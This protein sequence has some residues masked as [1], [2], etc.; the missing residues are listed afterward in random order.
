MP[1]ALIIFLALM[2]LARILLGTLFPVTA[3][4]SYYWLWSRHLTLSY[5]DHPP[6]VAYVNF[7]FTF[8]QPILFTL[9]LATTLI[10]LLVSIVVYFLAKEVYNEK[11]AFWSA[12]L[13]Q[14]IPHFLV[15]WL[16]MF[17]ELPLVLFWTTALLTTVYI[18]KRNKTTLWYLLAIIIGLGSLCKYTMFVFWPSLA[19]FFL[20]VPEQRF[21]LKTKEPYL[22]FI[23]SLLFFTPVIY[24]NSL[25]N[26]V[27]FTFH[28]A[29]TVGDSFGNNFLPFIADQLV[30][31]S[32][33]L[34]FALFGAYKY[35]LKQNKETRL[36][37]SFSFVPLFLFLILSLKVKVWAHW[38][39][40]GYIAAI[41]LTINYLM[42][43]KKKWQL[44]ITWIGLFSSLVI[45]ML[46]FV[47]PGVLL[48]QQE[49]SKNYELDK[50]IPENTK[51]FSQ[52]NVSAS[53]LE[54]HLNRPTYLAIGFLKRGAPWGEKQYDIWGIPNLTSGET[55]C[56][57]WEDNK[58][59]R[60]EVKKYF[61]NIADTGWQLN[62]VEDYINRYKIL[63]LEGFKGGK[64][65]P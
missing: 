53:L 65:H 47:T 16:T 29:K 59:F 52:T 1:L 37:F 13:F 62:L 49:Y 2:S 9:R 10:A 38:P 24:W 8:G 50:L 60:A 43:Q 55:V 17:V 36:L 20:I 7:L 41:P 22:C 6:M 57:Y 21:W 44:F 33:F 51:V 46:L 18:V 14:I 23:I 27:S 40:I 42:E 30:H 3:D 19:L 15:I 12:V 54:F 11:I 64:A 63:R 5:V 32:P 39:A 4:E 35:A 58:E 34:I 25:Y 28:G 45:I 31:F 48:H 26:F 61:K 56:Y